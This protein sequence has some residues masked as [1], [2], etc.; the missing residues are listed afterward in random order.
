MT[1]PRGVVALNSVSHTIR[2]PVWSTPLKIAPATAKRRQ[3]LP[4]A[5]SPDSRANSPR[6][7]RPNARSSQPT[8]PRLRLATATPTAPVMVPA[9]GAGGYGERT[10]LFYDRAAAR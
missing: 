1:E 5:K 8:R 4:P 3:H 6:D 10:G 9:V 7:R 2:G